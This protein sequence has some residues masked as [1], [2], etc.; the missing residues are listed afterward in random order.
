[1]DIQPIKITNRLHDNPKSP[2]QFSQE[3]SG[4]QVASP[5]AT[6]AMVALMD[7]EA[8]MGGA[9]CHFGGPSAFAEIMSCSF[10]YMF[11][12]SEKQ[13][14][15]WHEAYHFVNDAGHCEN[16]IYALKANYKT[17][18]LDLKSLRAFRSIESP[19][20]GHGE[21]YLFPEGVYISNGPLGSGIPQAQGLAAAESLSKT[22]RT[23]VVAI[24]DGGCMEGEAREALA[25]IPGLAANGRLGPLVCMLSDNN[26]KLS[27]RIDEDSFSM[28][29]S[30]EAIESLGWKVIKVEDGHDLKTVMKSVEKGFDAASKNPERPVFLWFKTIKGKGVEKTEKSS[31]GGHGFP[32]KKASE[33]PEFLKEIYQGEEVPQEFTAW[34]SELIEKEKSQVA[35]S[36][37]STVKKEKIQVG[38]SKAMIDAVEKQNL[39][40]ISISADLQGSTGVADFRK[41]FPKHSFEVGVAEANMVS[42]GIGFSKQGY[43]PVVDTFSQFGV[44]K[45][46]LPLIMSGLSHGPVIGV[47]SHTG[48]Q[49]AADGASHQAL[50]YMAMVNSIPHVDVYNLTCSDEAYALMTKTLEQFKAAREKGEVPNSTIFFLGREN[51]PQHFAENSKYEL[52]KYQILSEKLDNTKQAI[53]I[54][55]T[56][57]LVSYALKA[58]EALKQSGIGSIVVNASIVNKPDVVTLKDVLSKTNGNIVTLE[59]HRVDGGVGSYIVHALKKADVELNKFISLGVEDHFGRSA[60]QADQLYKQYGIDDQALVERVKLVFN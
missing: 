13:K 29:P 57:S 9:A 19:L 6:R 34:M 5:Q 24:S 41:K 38:I 2:P 37:A 32:L 21:A 27:G 4:Y 30:F 54:A 44:T 1:M 52:G 48:F 16:G 20:T 15:Q 31:S 35:T 7:M 25:A 33:L 56:G 8:V 23:T 60:Y 53:T 36:S 14:K 49:D 39:P 3:V 12:Q 17:A 45:G 40:V 46:A 18:G 26:T 10:A 59:D 51:F 43:I 11:A 47:F 50:S 28:N 42:T 55:V 22:P 58:Q